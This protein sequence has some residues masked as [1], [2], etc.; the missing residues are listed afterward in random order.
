MNIDY[1]VC[2]ALN[3]HTENI[4]GAI[5]YYD[6]G[7]QWHNNFLKR[8]LEGPYLSLPEGMTHIAAVGKFHL[9][10]HIK[11]CFV[12]YSPNFIQGVGQVDGEII[13]TLWSVFNM[14][15]RS[16]RTMSKAHRREVYDDHM[17]DSNWK[18]LVGMGE[19]DIYIR[20]DSELICPC[21]GII[22]QE[23]QKGCQGTS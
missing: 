5:E 3:Y 10:A 9:N 6:I 1:S 20:D 23:I 17:H 21:S 14:I 22:T 12:K 13:E 11:E 16:A 4:P 15:S 7:C 2:E 8:V 18:K 19:I